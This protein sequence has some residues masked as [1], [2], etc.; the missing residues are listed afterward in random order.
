VVHSATC[1]TLFSLVALRD[2]ALIPH[3]LAMLTL[4][5]SVGSIPLREGICVM[6]NLSTL[7]AGGTSGGSLHS[8]DNW[9]HLTILSRTGP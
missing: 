1:I 5:W 6:P 9:R 2:L 3:L 8:G 4:Y 7:K